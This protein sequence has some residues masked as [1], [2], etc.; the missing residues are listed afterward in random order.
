MPKDPQHE[1]LS[2]KKKMLL[3]KL[4]RLKSGEMNCEQTKGD[5]RQDETIARV[6]SQLREVETAIAARTPK[7]K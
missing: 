2:E 3:E 4:A 6:E 5:G 1:A 7:K